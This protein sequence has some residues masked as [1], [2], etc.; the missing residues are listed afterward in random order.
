M[1][2]YIDFITGRVY[3]FDIDTTPSA[4]FTYVVGQ[5]TSAVTLGNTTTNTKL[6]TATIPAGTLKIGDSVK[7]LFA[8]TTNSNANSKVVNITINN[9]TASVFGQLSMTAHTGGVMEVTIKVVS[10]TSL[11]AVNMSNNSSYST[12]TSASPRNYTVSNINSNAFT[13]D[14]YG[15]KATSGT[16]T[17][18]LEHFC[19][20]VQRS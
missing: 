1:Q 18:I 4:Q 6:A 8:V 5:N 11:R 13:I 17:L 20:I 3:Q 12:T 14:I 9:T 10:L 15:Q 16:D 19:A 7:I 2:I